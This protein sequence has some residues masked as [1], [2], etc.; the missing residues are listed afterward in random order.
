MKLNYRQ[1]L[2]E[3]NIQ[4]PPPGIENENFRAK[5]KSLWSDKYIGSL[6]IAVGISYLGFGLVSPLRTL[7][8][9]SEGA[10]GGEVGLMGA[11]FLFSGFVF[12]FPFGWLSDRVNRVNLIIGGLFAHLIIT[13]LY[14]LTTS[15]ELFI[16]LRFAEGI[17]AAAV[18]PAARAT[19]AD[20]IPKGRNGEAFGLMGA[21]ITFG[22][23]GGPPVGTF[24]AEAFGY[25]LAYWLAAGMFLPSIA[26]VYYAFRN[27]H[28]ASLRPADLANRQV[29]PEGD[30]SVTPADAETLWTV[31]VVMGS[32]FRIALG[33]G[34]GL[35][36]TV[37]S[38][39]MADL[40]FS[41]VL[42]GWTY[43]VY[44]VPMLLVSPSAGRFS[45]RYGRL[46]MMFMGGL[47]LGVV[48]VLYGILTTFIAFI[49][50]GIIEGSL[51]AIGRTANDGY[52]ADHSP[53]RQRGRAQAIFNAA[54]QL[55]SLVGAIA[56]GF[57]YEIDKALPFILLGIVQFILTA[58]C[59]VV[60]V[61]YHRRKRVLAIPD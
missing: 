2:V 57:L 1:N 22:M 51:D 54:T 38:I 6:I 20:L 10:S 28:Q 23:L 59:L 37:W 9:R 17:S 44:A 53:A 50:L 36:I 31:P 41:L 39:Y 49:I 43:T 26:L 52:L 30:L 5:R 45:D 15:G 11:A 29:K 55:G 27:Y 46:P 47:F 56:S 12:L 14:S 7:Y 42:I 18:M 35:A 34:P 40:G 58:L 24:L 3:D 4:L 32:L 33:I 16:A 48:W 25:T 13:L 60:L 61:V 21:A 8:A 19:L